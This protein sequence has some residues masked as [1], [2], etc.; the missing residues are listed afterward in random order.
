MQWEKSKL[1][2]T[3]VANSSHFNEF[4]QQLVDKRRFQEFVEKKNPEEVIGKRNVWEFRC[5][6]ILSECFLS[7]SIKPD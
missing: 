2:W 3:T 5:T 1:L 4:L 7:V 6:I